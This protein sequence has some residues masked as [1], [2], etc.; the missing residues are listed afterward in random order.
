MEQHRYRLTIWHRYGLPEKIAVDLVRNNNAGDRTLTTLNPDQAGLAP[1]TVLLEEAALTD[2]IRR[3]G[4]W[5]LTGDLD[6]LREKAEGVVEEIYR[7]KHGFV[8]Q[9]TVTLALKFAHETLTLAALEAA[10]I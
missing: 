4:V 7:N 3:A 1:L 5:S 8:D 10:L 6:E 2:Q 9:P